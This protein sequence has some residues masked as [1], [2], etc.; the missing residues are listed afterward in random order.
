MHLIA[1]NSGYLTSFRENFPHLI[2]VTLVA[3]FFKEKKILKNEK[4]R[5]RSRVITDVLFCERVVKGLL[6]IQQLQYNYIT[7]KSIVILL[8]CKVMLVFSTAVLVVAVLPAV[9]E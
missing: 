8:F 7:L 4:I 1:Y 2:E 6:V 5:R 3:C 9:P